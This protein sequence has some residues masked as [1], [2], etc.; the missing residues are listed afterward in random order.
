MNESNEE[1]RRKRK[2]TRKEEKFILDKCTIR[3][4]TRFKCLASL[5]T[6]NSRSDE[7]IRERV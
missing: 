4:V 1:K 2:E 6:E 3:T 5:I 7:Y